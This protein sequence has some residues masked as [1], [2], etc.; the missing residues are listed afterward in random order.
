MEDNN[1]PQE[2]P[3][4]DNSQT[5]PIVEEENSARVGADTQGESGRNQDIP[6][7]SLQPPT[8]VLF[9]L[10]LHL[11][12]LT[13]SYSPSSRDKKSCHRCNKEIGTGRNLVVCFDG[14]SN[15]FGKKNTNVLEFYSRLDEKNIYYNPGVGTAPNPKPST[16]QRLKRYGDLAFAHS[17]DHLVRQGY[18]WIIDVYEPGDRIYICG[19]SRGAYQAKTLAAM[20]TAVGLIPRGNDRQIPF[21]YQIY[22]ESE[23]SD[24]K[25]K[26][27]EEFKRKLTFNGNVG[28]HFLGIWDTVSSVGF[29]R[30]ERPGTT[31][32]H[33]NVC[34]VRHALALDECRVKFEPEYVCGNRPVP[35]EYLVNDER[36]IPR[37]KEV[38]FAGS[39]S[40]VGGGSTENRTLDNA[41]I[42]SLWMANQAMLAGLSLKPSK[43]NWVEEKLRTMCPTDSMKWFYRPIEILPVKRLKFHSQH[44]PSSTQP[45]TPSPDRSPLPPVFNPPNTTRRWHVFRGRKMLPGQLIHV[46]VC[47]MGGHYK[48]KAS[49]HGINWGDI[50]GMGVG[51]EKEA[52]WMPEE[53][54]PHF[55]MDLY[56]VAGAESIMKE[57]I[58]E[59]KNEEWAT[60]LNFLASVSSGVSMILNQA[61]VPSRLCEMIREKK[62]CASDLLTTLAKNDSDHLLICLPELVETVERGAST[63]NDKSLSGTLRTLFQNYGELPLPKEYIPVSPSSNDPGPS[64]KWVHRMAIS[65]LYFTRYIYTRNAN[66]L[67]K[68]ENLLLSLPESIRGSPEIQ[69]SYATMLEAKG[70]LDALEKAVTIRDSLPRPHSDM[71]HRILVNTRLNLATLRVRLRFSR[72]YDALS[73]I[74]THSRSV[75]LMEDEEFAKCL[76][77]LGNRLHSLDEWKDALEVAKES[78]TVFRRIYPDPLA[79][80]ADMATALNNFSNRLRGAGQLEDALHEME[81]AVRMR[82]TLCHGDDLTEVWSDLAI[83]LGNL[84]E[85]QRRL[86]DV[87]GAHLSAKEAVQIHR[88]KGSDSS[89]GPSAELASNLL[90]LSIV[91]QSLGRIEDALVTIQECIEMQEVL[92]EQD[93]MQIPALANT[94]NSLYVR[95]SDLGRHDE[96]LVAIQRA[97]SMREVLAH[98]RPAAFNQYLATSLNNLYVCLSDLGRHEEA[99]V[100]IQRAVSMGEV[101]AHDRPAAFNQDLAGS[102]FNLSRQYSQLNRHEDALEPAERSLALYREL[103]KTR[104]LVFKKE[105]IRGLLHLSNCLIHLGRN[106]EAVEARKELNELR[107]QASSGSFH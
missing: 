27:A 19:F 34:Y 86:G 89:Q 29:V 79:V 95:L 48:P 49:R 75:A 38:W 4:P 72:K 11:E 25:R 9:S 63:I 106:G 16:W 23:E 20:I 51:R 93:A 103:V 102:L 14:T 40:D 82:R 15:K 66:D 81:E 43:V 3:P 36:G 17:F 74:T 30:E 71:Y 52:D 2:Q 56:D 12:I 78:V 28:V 104:P 22:L 54:E 42:P 88:S 85:C 67:V 73:N 94:L 92:A 100:A 58:A 96:A 45:L 59:P 77:N 80:D 33:E 60:R 97:V 1:E 55:E 6:L 84:S 101:L 50:V 65:S 46:S 47:L 57:W 10:V 87:E 98:D 107:A 62:E 31:R 18:K 90:M 61:A 24:E 91:Q 7:K 35:P 69:N 68:S 41:A 70:T 64:L 83:S 8:F 32:V 13:S 39:H 105:V 37:V 99:L 53:L 5:T 76:S 44:V 26:D 21:A